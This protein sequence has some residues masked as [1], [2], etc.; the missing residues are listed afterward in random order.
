MPNLFC[1]DGTSLTFECLSCEAG[2]QYNI[3]Q[4]KFG[5]YIDDL[6]AGNAMSKNSYLA[7]QNVKKALPQLQ[8]HT[9]RHNTYGLVGLIKINS[10]FGKIMIAFF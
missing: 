7:V 10:C 8:V 9:W 3:K 5:K 6:I 4:I 2:R 1:Y